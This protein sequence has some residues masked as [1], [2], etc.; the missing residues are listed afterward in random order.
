MSGRPVR[1]RLL[2]EAMAGVVQRSSRSGMTIVG[3]A[4][5]VASFVAVLGV[6]A[7]ANGQISDEFL[8][9]EATQITV[10]PRSGGTGTELL[11]AADADSRV[12]QIDGVTATGRWWNVPGVTVSVNPPSIDPGS[13]Q[14][15]LLAVTPGYFDLVGADVSSG[16]TFDDFH[17]DQPV[18]VIGEK[19]AGDL[20]IDNVADQPVVVLNNL[21]VTV[22]GVVDNT[23]GSSAAL[24]SVIIPAGF[25]RE[26]F[27]APGQRETM[28]VATE[29]GA[30]TVVADQLA[31]A[32]N[33]AELTAYQI[34][35][36]PKPTVVKDRV[37]GSTQALFFALAGICVLV[38]G[39]GIANV[40]LLGVIARTR[41]IA[42]RRSLGALP[43]HIA[44][45]FLGESAVRGLLGGLVGTALAM[46]AVTVIALSQ[47]WTAVIEPWSLVAGPV[48]G[49]AIGS[50][51]GL[52]PAIRATKIEPVEAFRR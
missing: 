26:H 29:V 37:N 30:S 46:A 42:L 10:T 15:P 52:Y 9:V 11:F 39:V 18:A 8:K 21:R 23:T 2:N 35:P 44:I 32:L 3:I 25:A 22:I 36:P 41:E 34:V 1:R 6:T 31:V 28:V 4:I 16:R 43:R 50:I 33:P 49:V 17:Q 19:L 7:S 45:Q 48:M 13:S 27:T 20:G 14:P 5:G 47:Q 38:S 12:S 51:A 40:S 24:T